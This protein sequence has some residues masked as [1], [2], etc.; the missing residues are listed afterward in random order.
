MAAITEN[1][2]ARS[3]KNGR[4]PRAGDHLSRSED[5]YRRLRDAI[6]KGTLPPGTRNAQRAGLKL[7]R[8]EL[9]SGNAQPGET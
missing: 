1:N 5:A 7:M 9:V 2:L 6:R 8:S 3:E 4:E